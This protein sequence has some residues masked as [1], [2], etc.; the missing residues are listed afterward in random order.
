MH[1]FSR[2]LLIVAAAAALA[3]AGCSKAG[4][5]GPAEGDMSLGPADAKVKVVEYASASCSH[6]ARFNAEVFPAFKAKYIDTGKVQYTLKEFLTPPNQVAAA[7]FL[8]A[9][10]AGKDKYFPTLDAIFR[11]QEEMFQTEDAARGVLLRIA[12]SQGMTEKQFNACVSDPAAIDALNARVDKAAKE[13]KITGTPTLM[14]NGKKVGEG[15]VSLA[16][17]DAAIAAASR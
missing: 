12:Q 3:L 16:E 5:K 17:L 15:E 2:R 14:V 1:N 7:G 8:V 4:G 9:R 13:E 10:C 6:C 11:N